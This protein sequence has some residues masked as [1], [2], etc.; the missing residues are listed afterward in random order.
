MAS[1]RF[2]P[3]PLDSPKIDLVP[4]FKYGL[5]GVIKGPKKHFKKFE[6]NRFTGSDGFVIFPFSHYGVMGEN[7]IS[8]R[9]IQKIEFDMYSY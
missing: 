6:Q 9:K 8:R 3:L 2:T 4:N 1:L 7:I 5:G